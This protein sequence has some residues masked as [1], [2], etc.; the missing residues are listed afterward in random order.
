LI[1]RAPTHRL[2]GDDLLKWFVLQSVQLCLFLGNSPVQV[3][4][5]M[6]L[7]LSNPVAECL[8]RAEECGRLSKTAIDAASIE[9]FLKIE[10]RWLFLSRSHQFNERV[11]RFTGNLG[12][13]KRGQRRA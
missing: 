9:H 7:K 6:L 10:Q 12:S 2:R 8:R 5:T 3:L 1:G 13:G 11:N 4:A